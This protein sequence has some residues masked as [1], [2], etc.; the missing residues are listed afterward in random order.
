MRRRWTAL[1]ATIGFMDKLGKWLPPLALRLVLAYEF[2]TSGLEKLQGVNWFAEIQ[3]RFPPP[4]HL[5]PPDVSWLIALVVELG[6]SIALMLGLGTR[7]FSL[8]L[9]LLTLVAIASVHAGQGYNVCD[10]GWKLPLLYLI[11]LLPL[12]CNGPGR[13]SVDHVL[14][15]HYLRSERRIWG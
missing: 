7:A 10:N 5:V 13:L 8:L 15:L 12:I 2:G 3:D 11:M 14:R 1:A 4:L 9:A 6:G